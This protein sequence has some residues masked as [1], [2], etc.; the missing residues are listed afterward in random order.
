MTKKIKSFICVVLSF[1]M[2]LSV[3]ACAN[4]SV[5]NNGEATTTTQASQNNDAPADTTTSSQATDAP[6]TTEYVD[7]DLDSSLNFGGEEF[8]LLYWDDSS[9]EEF[10][11]EGINGVLV[12]D[13]IYTRNAAVEDRLGIKFKFIGEHGNEYNEAP[14]AGKVSNSISAG[15][16]AYDLIG[17]YSYTAGLCASQGLLYDLSDV[18]YLDFDKPWWPDM[19]INQATINNKI[20]FVSG[21]ISAN[22]IYMMYVTFF[23]KEILE[24][25]KLEDPYALV[26]QGK[27]TI[28]KQ[29]E[30]ASSVYEDLNGSGAK[31]SGDRCGLYIYT[32]HFDSFL[33][34]SNVFIVDSLQNDVKFSD[35]F[36]GEKTVNLQSKIS[37]FV[38]NNQGGL[39]VTD[40]NDAPTY[41]GNG[42]S[43]FWND[44]CCRAIDYAGKTLSYGIL[45]IAKYDEAQQSHVTIMGNPFSLYALPKDSQN[46]DMAG[47]V[48]ECMA[49]ESYR[50][51]T[52]ALYEESFKYKYSQDDVSAKMF[53]IAR[54]TVVFD[55]ARIFSNS[56]GAYKSWQ[57]AITGGVAWTTTVKGNERTWQKQLEKILEIFE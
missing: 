28:D 2:L 10:Y 26:E 44:R 50:T 5:D 49:S 34:G 23:N 43:L 15:D 9:Y 39:L 27:W 29:F 45:P 18:A 31:D 21:D 51:V 1:M 4:S 16:H 20:Y 25:Y 6:E 47:A 17:A 46:A 19:L 41:F 12:N 40:K 37:D 54:G 55:L 8:S 22:A 7:D 30:M 33:W 57:K 11:S 3:V 38:Y 14:F 13:A 36:L 42:F 52:P 32:L 48:I 35:D 24:N 53:D 56:L